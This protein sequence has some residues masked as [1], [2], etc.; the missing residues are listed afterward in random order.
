M[1][2]SGFT[3]LLGRS[4][5][6]LGSVA[7]TSSGPQAANVLNRVHARWHAEGV[8]LTASDAHRALIITLGRDQTLAYPVPPPGEDTNIFPLAPEP[9]SEG[10]TLHTIFRSPDGSTK[11]I[12]ERMAPVGISRTRTEP[13]AYGIDFGKIT[14]GLPYPTEAIESI[15][16]E[17]TK[18]Q[19]GQGFATDFNNRGIRSMMIN[20]VYVADG[21]AMINGLW[22]LVHHPAHPPRITMNLPPHPHAPM[23]FVSQFPE[24]QPLFHV[25]YILMP[26]G[27]P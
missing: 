20:P 26:Y 24:K 16:V 5:A 18:G 15:R 3:L 1:K 12:G 10:Q 8:T 17:L 2:L 23:N 14:D 25:E 22:A 9:W 7:R 11:V 19:Q 4:L 13:E 6:M 27:T 21:L